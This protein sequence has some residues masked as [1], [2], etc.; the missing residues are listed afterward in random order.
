MKNVKT[1]A[2]TAGAGSL[3]VGLDELGEQIDILR[4]ELYNFFELIA[5]VLRPV[6]FEDQSPGVQV[7]ETMISP[8]AQRINNLK[9]DII[10]TTELI[11]TTSKAVDI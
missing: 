10:Q 6:D 11:N 3:T 5:P 1:M 9:A 2:T 4:K 8:V 7:A